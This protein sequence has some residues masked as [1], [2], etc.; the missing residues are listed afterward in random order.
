VLSIQAFLG[1]SIL[2]G[3]ILT[4]STPVASGQTYS[5]P[6]EHSILSL[7][8]YHKSLTSVNPL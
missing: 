2:K 5:K 4:V 7:T 8:D 3:L 1:G 6:S